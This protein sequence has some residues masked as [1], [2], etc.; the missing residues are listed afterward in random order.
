MPTLNVHL[1][2][3]SIPVS[4]TPGTSIYEILNT[5]NI[6]IRGGC[7]GIGKCGLCQVKIKNQGFKQ[8]CRVHPENDINIELA[9]KYILSKW[10]KIPGAEYFNIDLPLSGQV[11]DL[12]TNNYGAAVDLGTTHIRVSV[13]D[14]NNATRIGGFTGVNPQVYLGTDVLTRL[15]AALGSKIHTQKLKEL[16]KS[17]IAKAIRLTAESSHKRN[18]GKRINKIAIVGNTAMLALLTGQ[19]CGNLLNADSSIAGIDFNI[20]NKNDWLKSL[21]INTNANIKIVQPLENF[22]GSDFLSGVLAVKLLSSPPGSV[23]IDFGTNS[24]IGLWDG[25]NLWTSS[26]AGGPA[27]EGS[28][29]S[30]GMPAEPGAVYRVI[31][32]LPGSTGKII[33]QDFDPVKSL[34]TEVIGNIE[35]KG[36]CGS[37]LVD[38]IACLIKTGILKQNGRFSKQFKSRELAFPGKKN[39]FSLTKQDID[40]FQ[41][42][43]GAIG[44]GIEFLL[45]KA[46]MDIQDIKRVCVCGAFGRY[47][48]IANAQTLGLLPPVSKHK[49]ELY[50]NTALAGCEYLLFDQNYKKTIDIIRTKCKSVNL[51]ENLLYEEMFIKNLFLRPMKTDN[52]K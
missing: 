36:V 26:A 15:T 1:E 33:E 18:L 25:K 34:E 51:A 48:D 12:E 44:S 22:V 2:K 27:F 31:N 39:N 8:A 19:G 29:I 3:T 7:G 49:I 52:K 17:A 21:D 28:G 5:N 11:H 32:A 50:A 6:Q 24:E 4:F 46:G 41:R 38:A 40:I 20:K 10:R 9:D 43:K 47:L 45:S 13:W 30:C 35:A 42:A 23:F 37:G 14:M 16:V